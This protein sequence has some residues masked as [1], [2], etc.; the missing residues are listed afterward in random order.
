MFGAVGRPASVSGRPHGVTPGAAAGTVVCAVAA[1]GVDLAPFL[2][3]W[4]S[5]ESDAG[6]HQAL[7][8]RP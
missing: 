7:P 2:D 8:P 5:P 1:T 3:A 6:V 4:G